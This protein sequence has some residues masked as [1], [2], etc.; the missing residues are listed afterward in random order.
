MNK[1]NKVLRI[2][3]SLN[4]KLGGPPVG[5]INNSIALMR[6]GFEVDILTSDP[7][8][9]NYFKNKNIKIIN[10]GSGI[11]KYGLNFKLFFWLIKNKKKYDNFI[12][13]G[14]WQFNTLIARILIKK[15]YYVFPHGSL[16]PYY[17]TEFFKKLKKQIYWLLIEKR[18]LLECKSLLL[19]SI[20]EKKNILKSY[21]NTS[22]I[23]LQ[24]MQ[25]GILKPEIDLNNAKKIFTNK[26]S[27]LKNKNFYIFI[28]RFHQVKGCDILLRSVKKVLDKKLQINILMVGPNNK[29]KTKLIKLCKKLKI[30]KN[31]FWSDFLSG[32]LKWGAI[33]SSKAMLLPSHAENF[34]ISIVE[35]LSTGTPVITTNKVN[36]YKDIKKYK[37]GFISNDN[38]NS[39]SKN[40]IKFL[41]YKN[42]KKMKSNALNCFNKKFNLEFNQQKFISL[43]K[44]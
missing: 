37:A 1:N 43:L 38:I 24:V 26:F 25:Y 17:S 9:S 19:T 3:T 27:I 41:K 34:G 6:N 10:L 13:H 15:K 14:L 12:I 44:N 40:L 2:V 23:N 35:A 16:N 7:I 8:N 4:P 39:F 29:Y 5:I 11:G 31:V 20:E 21:V 30:S 32:N 42:Q 22:N 18:N 28:G 33:A 36:I